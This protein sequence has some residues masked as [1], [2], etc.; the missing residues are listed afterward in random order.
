MVA[1]ETCCTPLSAC[2][3]SCVEMYRRPCCVQMIW[4]THRCSKGVRIAKVLKKPRCCASAGG[5]KHTSALGS[6]AV[7]PCDRICQAGSG[8]H[9]KQRCVVHITGVTICIIRRDLDQW[10]HLLQLRCS[11]LCDVAVG[12]GGARE[13]VG[14]WTW[15]LGVMLQRHRTDASQ[16][17]VFCNL[18]GEASAVDN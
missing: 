6:Q 9:H 17:N 13:K 2:A 3:L 14:G 1:K 4:H 18:S 11:G 10:V 16:H 12:A 5:N 7:C 8:R 15:L